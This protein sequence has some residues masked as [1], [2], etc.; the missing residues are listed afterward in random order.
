MK[1]AIELFNGYNDILISL[2]QR[3]TKITNFMRE[4]PQSKLISQMREALY[5]D[6]FDY[7]SNAVEY[8]TSIESGELDSVLG[9]EKSLLIRNISREIDGCREVMF[10]MNKEFD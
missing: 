7:Y 5:T 9:K 2:N 10:T 8:I 6:Y 4:S 1:D 3:I